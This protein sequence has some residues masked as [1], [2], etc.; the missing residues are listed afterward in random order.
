MASTRV[1]EP[2]VTEL[3][4]MGSIADVLIWARVGGDTDDPSSKSGSLL[5]ALGADDSAL[6]TEIANADPTDFED[7]F[8]SWSIGS[9]T[10]GLGGTEPV[11]PT[12]IDKGRARAMHKACRIKAELDWSTADTENWE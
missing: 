4:A 3:S 11:P 2:S 1:T 7:A 8:A 10:L 9:P 12:A 5:A 6:I